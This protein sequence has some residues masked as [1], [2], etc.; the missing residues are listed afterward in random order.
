MK[1]RRPFADGS[2]STAKTGEPIAVD[3]TGNTKVM[4][5][6]SQQTTGLEKNK[7]VTGL[8]VTHIEERSEEDPSSSQARPK[9]GATYY[10]FNCNC[11]FSL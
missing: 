1:K 6:T 7:S 4:L 3:T 9:E 5:N 10:Y 11:L 8:K 2:E